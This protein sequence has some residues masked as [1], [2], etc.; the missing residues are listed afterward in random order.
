MIGATYSTICPDIYETYKDGDDFEHI[1]DNYIIETHSDDS[2][3]KDYLLSLPKREKRLKALSLR[4]R[5]LYDWSSLIDKITGSRVSNVDHLKQII[6]DFREFIKMAKVE[7]KIFGEVM[8]PFDELARPMVDLVEKYD[9]DF[10]KSPKK[11]LDSSA[12]IGTFL[13]ICAAKFMNGLKDYP[14]LEDPEVRFRFIVE[15]CLYYGELQSGNASLWLSVIDPYNEYITNTF[16]GSYLSDKDGKYNSELNGVFDKHM[17]E[18]WKVDNFDLIIQNPPYSYFKETDKNISSKNPKTQP[19]WQFFV[20]KSIKILKEGGFMVMVHP[21]GWRDINGVFKETQNLLKERKIL[22]LHMFSFKSGLDMFKAK[23]NFDYYILKNEK[24]DGY[25][26][27]IHCE[28]GT[29]ERLNLLDLDYIPGENISMINNLFAKNDEELI[30]I[31]SDS[32]YHT[33]QGEKKGFLSKIKT[34]EFNLPVVYMVSYKNEP[35]FWYSCVDKGHFNRRKVI[36]A[37]GSS[38]VIIDENGDYGLTQFSRAI[39]D[40][41]E[42]L[43]KIKKALESDKFI[44][45]VMLFKDG[46]GHKYNNKVISM[47]KKDFWKDFI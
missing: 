37:N 39:V 19:M 6:K 32:S 7:D 21:G 26:T 2:Y 33:Q 5:D 20:Q 12:G 34:D 10:W 14:G 43:E 24:N 1:I 18:V 11:V 3:Q 41:I 4:T 29:I 17:K 8:T 27:E 13:I 25:I 46:L 23:T 36:W 30:N 15:K 45:E 9:T 40:D 31:I 38:G 28:N 16:W 42:N 35:S 47:L 22:E 44:K